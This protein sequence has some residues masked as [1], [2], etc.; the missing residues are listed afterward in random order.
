[1]DITNFKM[2]GFNQIIYQKVKYLKTTVYLLFIYYVY[3]VFFS[4]DVHIIIVIVII[5]YP[6]DSFHII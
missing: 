4:F 1:M 5:M 3:I 6:W 2:W